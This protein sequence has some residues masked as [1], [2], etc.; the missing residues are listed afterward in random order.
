MR[1]IDCDRKWTTLMCWTP[2]SKYVAHKNNLLNSS[3]KRD[4]HCI[5]EI[6]MPH[7]VIINL[8][9]YK[10]W[11]GERSHCKPI[12][13]VNSNSCALVNWQMFLILIKICLII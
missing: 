7:Q 13:E 8:Q 6:S 2:G 10:N 4:D 3:A 12:Q 1:G 9:I 5:E 11:L